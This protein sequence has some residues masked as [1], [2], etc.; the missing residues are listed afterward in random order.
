MPSSS[1]VERAFHNSAGTGVL[2]KV[3]GLR[4][5]PAGRLSHPG[6]HTAVSDV[7][8]HAC[9]RRRS[10][11]APGKEG[12]RRIVHRRVSVVYNPVRLD[13][14]HVKILRMHLRPG[15]HEMLQI[16][17]QS[18]T[19][20]PFHFKTASDMHHFKNEHPD[21]CVC[22][23][24]FHC[25]GLVEGCEVYPYPAVITGRNKIAIQAGSPIGLNIDLLLWNE[26]GS[27]HGKPESEGGWVTGNFG[28]TGKAAF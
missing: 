12:N 14:Y 9:T 20:G 4:P 23:I 16:P 11:P 7:G 24:V 17:K 22:K 8:M 13:I 27:S 19:D 2:R 21:P 25:G 1:I 28:T 15:F 26:L 3:P 6:N 10:H 18:K 5:V